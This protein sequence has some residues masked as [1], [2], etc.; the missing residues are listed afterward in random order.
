[1]DNKD[2]DRDSWRYLDSET[3]ALISKSLLDTNSNSNSNSGSPQSVD[4]ME[5]ASEISRALRVWQQHLT[6]GVLPEEV[7]WPAEPLLSETR[8]V[9]SAIDLP[10]MTMKHPELV[11]TVCRSL[12]R[13]HF[14]FLQR[15]RAAAPRMDPDLES[16][17]TNPDSSIYEYNSYNFNYYEETETEE[18]EEEVEFEE[19]YEISAEKDIAQLL[20]S[21]FRDAWAPSLG[22]IAALDELYGPSHGLLSAAD[23]G[24]GGG[25]PSGAAPSAADA[26]RERGFGVFDGVWKRAGWE[27]LRAVQK[28]LRD[29]TE[30][31][32]LVNS[33]G[34]RP[35]G[36]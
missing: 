31:R 9:F 25:S 23:G 21:R 5:T 11:A 14:E 28:L 18:A 30:L 10:L 34:K 12:V 17:V 16:E 8:A 19:N 36:K 27:R 1:L 24:I 7:D 22:G 26:G 2:K 3:L 33:L 13:L 32:D 29:M 6:N 35:V 20:A 15:V 4:F